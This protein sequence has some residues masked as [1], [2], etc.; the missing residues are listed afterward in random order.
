M[1]GRLTY[2][3]MY[4]RAILF[5]VWSIELFWIHTRKKEKGNL[6]LCLKKLHTVTANSWFYE[7]PKYLFPYDCG[8]SALQTLVNVCIFL[9]CYVYGI[10]MRFLPFAV[11]KDG[12]YREQS[13]NW[14][15]TPGS[16]FGKEEI[17]MWFVCRC[18]WNRYMVQMI[19]NIP[20]ARCSSIY[21]TA[22]TY[23]INNVLF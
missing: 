19:K 15:D 10:H 5:H 3:W 11:I 8:V 7:H 21:G 17:H 4:T 12:R 1:L 14:E 23:T 18:S 9:C 13:Q 22:S 2:K 6:S 16:P 20:P